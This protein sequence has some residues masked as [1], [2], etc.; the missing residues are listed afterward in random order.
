MDRSG[1]DARQT[2]SAG[3]AV[4]K[5]LKHAARREL[6]RGI[7]AAY[8]LSERRAC[9][10]GIA[11]FIHTLGFSAVTVSIYRTR[12]MPL[13]STRMSAPLNV[14]QCLQ[15]FFSLCRSRS[16]IEQGFLPSSKSGSDWGTVTALSS[17]CA[18]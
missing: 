6:V 18:G 17:I 9:G 12:D 15:R 5:S 8:Q 13:H 1:L 16:G 2:H 3:S 14:R 10:L 11:T 4:K 7:R